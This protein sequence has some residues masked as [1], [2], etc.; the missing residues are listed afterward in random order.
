MEKV[1]TLAVTR[2]TVECPQQAF[3]HIFHTEPFLL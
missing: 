3:F 2:Y 1:M